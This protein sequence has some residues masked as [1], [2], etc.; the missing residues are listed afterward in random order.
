MRKLELELNKTFYYTFMDL[1][2]VNF[3]FITKK[4]L[5]LFICYL[6][7]RMFGPFPCSIKIH[8]KC[9]TISIFT[10]L[11]FLNHNMNNR[12]CKYYSIKFYEN[13]L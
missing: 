2:Y 10:H 7:I 4:K 8:T 12:L 3:V 6:R 9:F 11:K 5:T 1:V 13:V